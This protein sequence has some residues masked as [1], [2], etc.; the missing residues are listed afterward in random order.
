MITKNLPAAQIYA[1]L[2]PES[3]R[4]IPDDLALYHFR[5][6][7]PAAYENTHNN[8]VSEMFED[9]NMLQLPRAFIE[10]ASK[11]TSGASKRYF[12]GL[13]YAHRHAKKFVERTI[14]DCRNGHLGAA[15][16]K[17]LNA[18]HLDA[19]CKAR[20]QVLYTSSYTSELAFDYAVLEMSAL[21]LIHNDP[22]SGKMWT[23]RIYRL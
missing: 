19:I 2:L 16:A 4:I 6:S 10:H 5:D 1:E 17:H 23:N 7:H 12:E 11:V 3:V 15:E 13:L 22:E 8:V 9:H 14:E 20:Y 21:L 18:V